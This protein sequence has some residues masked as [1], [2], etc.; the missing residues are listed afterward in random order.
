MYVMGGLIQITNIER[1][2]STHYSIN[3]VIEVSGYRGG[4]GDRVLWVRE[5]ITK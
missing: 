1:G 5:S 4:V 3:I 2:L